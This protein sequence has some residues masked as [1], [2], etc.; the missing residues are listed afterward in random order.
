MCFPW[1]VKANKIDSLK[2]DKDVIHFISNL[3]Q[4]TYERDYYTFSLNRPD[5]VFNF[6][7]CDSS[8]LNWRTKNWEKIDFNKDN[9]TDLFV[10]LYIRDTINSKA[11]YYTIYVAIDKGDNHFQLLEIPDYFMIHC[12]AAKPVLINGYPYIIYRHFKTEFSMDSL[13]PNIQPTNDNY[14]YTEIGN[15]DTLIYKYGGFIELNKSR[16]RPPIK[17]L[18]FEASSCLG[19]CPAFKMNIFKDGTAYY[20]ADF[21]NNEEGNFRATIKPK[22]LNE[23]LGLVS[24][25]NVSNLENTYSELAADMPTAYLT[26]YFENGSIKKIS[27]YGQ[28]GTLGLV[29]LYKLLFQLRESQKWK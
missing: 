27:D 15:T 6:Y 10:T 18:F 24:Y 28:Q 5:S 4:Q 20:V 12:F 11:A 23:I 7:S 22:D 2:T 29:R 25:L 16:L 9:L 21:F 14:H 13:P 8:V 19:I 17:S 3:Y 26:I 1:Q